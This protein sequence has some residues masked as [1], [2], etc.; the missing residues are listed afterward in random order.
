MSSK[1]E[2]EYAR[3]RYEEYQRRQAE[4]AALRAKRRRQS[5]VASVAA[6][7]VVAVV[8]AAF[9]VVGGG[10][11]DTTA[12]PGGAT[13]TSTAPA[14]ACPAPTTPPPAT[15]KQWATA[16]AADTAKGK[17]Y[18]MTL[19]TSCGD[20]VLS[21]DGSKAP[22]AVASTVFLGRNGFYDG[23]RCH[24]LTTQGI[25]VLQC[26]DPTQTGGGGP[27]YSYGPVENAPADGVYKAGT[28]AMARQGEKGDSMGSQFFLVYEDSPIPSD[29]AGGYTVLGTVTSGL[30]V[31]RKVADAGETGGAGDGAP[32]TPISI[33]AVTV[34][35]AS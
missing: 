32:S 25:F 27:G 31:V 16:P 34:S 35:P 13:A 26:G 11:D 9:L 8:L 29:T 12:A 6:V 20:V 21:L 15:P 23:T 19:K 18:T 14:D 22:Q 17:T 10:D 2:R 3:R 4:R 1:R 28:V 33:D 24:R 30:D 7:G 5:I